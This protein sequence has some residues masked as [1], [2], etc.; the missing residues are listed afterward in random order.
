MPPRAPLPLRTPPQAKPPPTFGDRY[1][2]YGGLH[3]QPPTAGLAPAAPS[4]NI[5]A[6]EPLSDAELLELSSYLASSAPLDG[7]Y[8]GLGGLGLGGGGGGAQYGGGDMRSGGLGLQPYQPGVAA[9]GNYA[10][11]PSLNAL[12]SMPAYLAAMWV[13]RPECAPWV[14]GRGARAGLA[15]GSRIMLVAWRSAVLTWRA[16][17]CASACDLH[18]AHRAE[19]RPLPCA[20]PPARHPIATRGV[21]CAGR[22]LTRATLLAAD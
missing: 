11:N 6:A 21:G 20:R 13:T 2:G 22:C 10:P 8:G 12:N 7:S 15:V 18:P 4:G 9:Y 17:A 1:G 16:C 3:S 14:D 5:A 19:P